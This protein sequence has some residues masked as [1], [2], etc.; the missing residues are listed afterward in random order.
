[1]QLLHLERF[2]WRRAK[3]GPEGA[4]GCSLAYPGGGQQVSVLV[5]IGGARGRGA[6]GPLAEQLPKWIKAS[7]MFLVLLRIRLLYGGHY[8]GSGFHFLP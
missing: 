4:E 2:C 5:R 6:S 7:K 1:M 3:V 8:T